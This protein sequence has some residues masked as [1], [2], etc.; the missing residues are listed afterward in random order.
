MQI[1][2]WLSVWRI[3]RWNSSIIAEQCEFRFWDKC[4][5]AKSIFVFERLFVCSLNVFFGMCSMSCV[6]LT[7]LVWFMMFVVCMQQPAK[8]L[9][10]CFASEHNRKQMSQVLGKE[11]WTCVRLFE[12]ASAQNA[13]M[14]VLRR[15]PQK[16]AH[17]IAFLHMSSKKQHVLLVLPTNRDHTQ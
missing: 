9:Q 15:L 2:G 8:W 10:F 4:C 7:W 5:I 1:M 13:L 11:P 16:A 17:I 3:M 14:C 6:R 12:W